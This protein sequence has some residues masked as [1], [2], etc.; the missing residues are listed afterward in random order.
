MVFA[1]QAD[2]ARYATAEGNHASSG[3]LGYYSPATNR[4]AMY[5]ITAGRAKSGSGDWTTNAET[6]IHEALHQSLSIP[7]S[8]T[9]SAR[10]RAGSPRD[11]ARCSRP[12][13]SGTRGNTPPQ[14][15]A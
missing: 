2:F 7:G 4:I 14:P 15:I 13:A 10:R 6:I 8:T 1:K 11:W 3:M 9:A 5:D 12:A